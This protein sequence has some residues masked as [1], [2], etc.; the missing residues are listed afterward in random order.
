MIDHFRRPKWNLGEIINGELFYLL[1]LMIALVCSLQGK[2]GIHLSGLVRY[3]VLSPRENQSRVEHSK[4]HRFWLPAMATSRRE[5]ST[6]C[7]DAQDEILSLPRDVAL[8]VDDVHVRH[9]HGVRLSR[10]CRP[11]GV[12]LLPYDGELPA[13]DVRPL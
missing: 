4:G 12:L 2:G 7:R 6:S 3:G 8:H 1:P 13:R 11:D 9:E 5:G 10:D